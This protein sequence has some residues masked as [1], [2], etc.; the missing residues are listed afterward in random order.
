MAFEWL[1]DNS[2]KFLESGYLSD[3][4]TAKQR[5]RA[6]GD[7]AE[8]ILG[9]EGF[10][11]KVYDNIGNDWNSFSSPLW[12]NFSKGRGFPISCFNSH[13]P[14]NTAGILSAHAE[15]GIMSKMGGGTSG[16]FGDVRSRGSK[17]AGEGET[18]GAVHFMELF[19]SATDVISQGGVRRGY[20][21]STLPIDHGDIEEFLE[22]GTEGHPIQVMNTSVSVKDYWLEEMIAGDKEK[23]K[24][25]GKVLKSRDEIGFP[26][27]YFH[28]AAN[29]NK[30]DVYKDNDMDILSSNLC[31]EILL[32]SNDDESFVCNLMSLNMLHYDEWKNTDLIET[33]VF[34]LDAVMTDFIEKLEALRDS[35]HKEDR[36]TFQFMERPYNF[37]KRHR[38]LGLGVLGWASF[39]QSKGLPFVSE[40]S[41]KLT[42]EC[43]ENIQQQSYKASEELA[44]M[45]GEPELLKGY[46]RRNTTLNALAPTTSSAFIQGQISQSIEP[47]MS[48][49]YIK[50]LAKLKA[51]IK[52][53]FLEKMLEEKGINNKDTWDK[54][55]KDD[56]SV[57]GLTELT[58]DEK[59]VFLTFDEIDVYGIIDQAAV[60]QKY[61]DQGQSLNL[62]IPA[63]FTTKE[64]NK[65]TL[66]AWKKGLCTLY[67]QHS[68]NAAQQFIR[69]GCGSACEA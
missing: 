38:A 30:P 51:V 23:R 14:D 64:T 58:D 32:P 24:I 20:M 57:L 2:R 68:V 45:Y 39:L 59:E 19:Q 12:A 54:I 26:Y 69:G 10:S 17:I 1:N 6:I 62:K 47:P 61:L 67:Y 9:I 16:Y 37:A 15:V 48:N 46:G 22:V 53:P 35:D 13:V 27:V 18:S 3:G 4:E 28:D 36:Q 21:A 56:G 60:R 5:I 66:H 11:D 33:C 42:E 7:R 63:N 34:L 31:H 40:E 29:R 44:R 55:A 25:W 8:E 50:D 41:T 49:F 52:N 65:V 43:F